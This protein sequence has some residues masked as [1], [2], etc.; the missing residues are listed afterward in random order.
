VYYSLSITVD[1]KKLG[2]N[3]ITMI[4]LKCERRK[5]PNI[6]N[7]S[8]IIVFCRTMG[9]YDLVAALEDFTACI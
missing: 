7:T 9:S 8:N 2:Y 3:A 4:F 5:M 6:S 1:L